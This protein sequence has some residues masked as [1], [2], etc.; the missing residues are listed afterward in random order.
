VNF[1]FTQYEDKEIAELKSAA[2]APKKELKRSDIKLQI[3]KQLLEASRYMYIYEGFEPDEILKVTKNM[4]LIALNKDDKVYSQ[5]NKYGCIYFLLKG[6]LAIKTAQKD[7]LIK[8]L[9]LFGEFLFLTK[10]ENN[11][12]VV[13]ISDSAT[14]MR[15]DINEDADCCLMS[16]IYANISYKIANQYKNKVSQIIKI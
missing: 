4:Q 12:D 11:T 5:N 3:Q 7:V 2:K 1:V 14:L 15:F 6:K 16:M 13:V 10:E 9:N 8:P